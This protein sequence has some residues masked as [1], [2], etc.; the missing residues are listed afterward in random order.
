MVTVLLKSRL[1]L[2]SR[3][4]KVKTEKKKLS[5]HVSWPKKMRTTIVTK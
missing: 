3:H 4:P 1:P 2:I 5:L